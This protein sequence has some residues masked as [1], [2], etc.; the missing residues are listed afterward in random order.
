MRTTSTVILPI[1]AL[2]RST[3]VA[4]SDRIQPFLRDLRDLSDFNVHF[5][6]QTILRIQV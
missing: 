2:T 3:T 1:I 6:N 5:Y 4:V